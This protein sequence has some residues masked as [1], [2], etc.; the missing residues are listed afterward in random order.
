MLNAHLIKKK[1]FKVCTKTFIFI[2]ATTTLC[3]KEF[4]NFNENTLNYSF[5]EK[6]KF[7][8]LVI[9]NISRICPLAGVLQKTAKGQRVGEAASLVSVYF[10]PQKAATEVS[11]CR[12]SDTSPLLLAFF[13]LFLEER[14]VKTEK[15]MFT[16]F[17]LGL[18]HCF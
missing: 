10:T 9:S 14:N 2:E 16:Q 18:M 5:T 12:S 13:F 8:Q 11:K 7:Y 6:T 4:N 1:S 17:L 15:H 3:F